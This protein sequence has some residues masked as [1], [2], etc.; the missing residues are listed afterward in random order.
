MLGTETDDVLRKRHVGYWML[1]T[2]GILHY[3]KYT[4][5]WMLNTDGIFHFEYT[6][7]W[8]LSTDDILHFEYIGYWMLSTAF[9]MSG[10]S[11]RRNSMLE[12]GSKSVN[13]TGFNSFL[14]RLSRGK[15]QIGLL[16]NIFL[17]F[18]CI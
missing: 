4:G 1:I 3:F 5:Y 17:F 8:M 2:D 12:I 18:L 16:F 11:G 7:Y 10:T 15:I 14:R 6:G 9:I 13:G